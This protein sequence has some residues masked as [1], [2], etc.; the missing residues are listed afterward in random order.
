MFTIWVTFVLLT[1]FGSHVCLYSDHATAVSWYLG[2]YDPLLAYGL[3][4]SSQGVRRDDTLSKAVLLGTLGNVCRRG[5]PRESWTDDVREL[6]CQ[7][8]SSL[9][10]ISDDRSQWTAIATKA[11]GGAP[12][13]AQAYGGKY[14]SLVIIVEA[15]FGTDTLRGVA[16]DA[17]SL[18]FP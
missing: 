4:A 18:W 5:R 12:H 15:V 8:L 17:R 9:L 1:K 3:L 10:R 16:F 7:S 13:D 11:S 2:L 6:T 14:S